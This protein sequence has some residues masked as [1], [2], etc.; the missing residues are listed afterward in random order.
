MP[1]S[2]SRRT[3]R[4]AVPMNWVPVR[5]MMEVASIPQTKIGMRKRVIPGARS[6]RMVTM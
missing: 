6:F 3:I 4:K 2:R 1:M 5:A